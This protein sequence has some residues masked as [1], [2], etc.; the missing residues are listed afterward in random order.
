MRTGQFLAKRGIV[1]PRTFSLSFA[2]IW[3]KDRLRGAGGGRLSAKQILAMLPSLGKLIITRYKQKCE[4]LVRN[5][6]PTD[7]LVHKL[8]FPLC[9]AF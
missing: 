8:L 5:L 1:G 4:D 2:H 3:L 9:F 7:W 6:L